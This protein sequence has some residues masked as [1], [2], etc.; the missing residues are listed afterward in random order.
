MLLIKTCKEKSKNLYMKIKHV[1]S[2]R[3]WLEF[4]FV[5]NV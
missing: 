1:N 4:F 2:N 5:E 3:N